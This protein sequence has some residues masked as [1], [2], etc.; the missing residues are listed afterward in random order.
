M[1]NTPID[2]QAGTAFIRI[3]PLDDPTQGSTNRKGP[4]LAS[5]IKSPIQN[6]VITDTFDTVSKSI[7]AIILSFSDQLEAI[8]TKLKPQELTIEFSLAFEISSSQQLIPVILSTSEK[9]TPAIKVI[10]T[11]KH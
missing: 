2:L 11:W 3:Y 10:A 1:K 6:Q 8:S 4:T 7:Q 5:G 9:L